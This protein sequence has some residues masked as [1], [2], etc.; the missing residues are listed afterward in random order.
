MP[1]L[2]VSSTRR[3][4][5]RAAA[6]RTA[7]RGF[8]LVEIIVAMT[9]LAIVL[10]SLAFLAGQAATR[11][12]RVAIGTYR[13]ALASELSDRFITMPYDSMAKYAGMDSLMAGGRRY[14]RRVTITAVGTTPPRS[15]VV[16]KVWPSASRVRADTLTTTLYRARPVVENVLNQGAI[17]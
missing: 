11:A 14:V 17:Q 13:S 7:R 12:K 6:P 4:L 3:A 10:S 1:L 16:I 15:S 2:A 8:S 9:L 5:R